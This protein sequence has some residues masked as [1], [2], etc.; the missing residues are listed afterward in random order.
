M[1]PQWFKLLVYNNAHHRFGLSFPF[2]I[3]ALE[4]P[5]GRRLTANEARLAL[6]GLLVGM[7]DET[8]S[9]HLIRVSEC[10]RLR[11]PV[12]A[13]I[14][15]VFRLPHH[16]GISPTDGRSPSLFAS[17]EY[18]SQGHIVE[19]LEDTIWRANGTA[20]LEGRYSHRAGQWAVLNEADLDFIRA[21]FEL[22]DD[23]DL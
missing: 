11:E 3:G 14:D 19:A 13:L 23:E 10:D 1:H 22:P 7:R 20:I 6:H 16:V 9:T 5:P 2:L 17:P 15:S 4:V 18:L 21:A 8:P 12:A